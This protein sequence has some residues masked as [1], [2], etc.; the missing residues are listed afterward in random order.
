[1]NNTALIEKT[2]FHDASLLTLSAAGDEAALFFHNV[3]TS[4]D[5]AYMASVIIDGVHNIT[6]NGEPVDL[7]SMEEQY[8]NV[9][10]FSR[11]D[12]VAVLLVEW[13]SSSPPRGRICSYKFGFSSFEIYVERQDMTT[14]LS[15]GSVQRG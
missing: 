9:I 14:Q 5:D 3:W 1:M 6:R 12:N 2:G 7:L 15:S 11:S 10:E 8:A 4:D 13:R